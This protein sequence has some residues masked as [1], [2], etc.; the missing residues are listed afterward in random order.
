MAK[1]P[2]PDEW[3]SLEWDVTFTGQVYAANAKEAKQKGRFPA[4]ARHRL[5]NAG[6][7]AR[8]S[9]NCQRAYEEAFKALAPA[10]MFGRP[11][12]P[13]TTQF[14]LTAYRASAGIIFHLDL[15][16]IEVKGTEVVDRD[17]TRIALGSI[18]RPLVGLTRRQWLDVAGARVRI[19]VQAR[20]VKPGQ[21]APLLVRVCNAAT[22]FWE[23]WGT[24]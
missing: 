18:L 12:K 20:H 21:V 16:A 15:N 4:E 23:T 2:V 11:W 6:V 19:G 7:T 8:I 14:F 17:A 9:W 13:R 10:R 22:R 24:P 1:R 3:P 5:G